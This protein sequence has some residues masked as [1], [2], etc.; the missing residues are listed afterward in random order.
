MGEGRWKP[1]PAYKDSWVEWLGEIPEHWDIKRLKYLAKANPSKSELSSVDRKLLVTFLPMELVQFG[2]ISLG[3]DRALEDV[4]QGFTYFRNGDVLIAKITP[5]FENGKGALAKNLTNGIGF[6][7]T[8]LHVLRSKGLYHPE[9]LYY[10][11]ISYIFRTVGAVFMHGTA[12][13]K[14][15]EDYFIVNFPSPIFSIAEQQAIANFLD[16]ETAKID[17]LI[18]K[19]LRLIELLQEKR[20]AL[21]SQ[22]V[23]K[24]LNPDVPMKDSGIEWLGEIP[25][26]WKVKK[27]KYV[28]K[29]FIGL[30]YD[31]S[32]VVDESN[33]MLVLRASNIINGRFSNEGNVFVNCNIPDNL[34]TKTNDILICARSGSRS[35]I[36][37]NIKL[38]H[39]RAGVTFGAFMLVFRSQYND[40]LSYVLNP[41]SLNISQVY[42]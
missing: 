29:A 42:F 4:Y 15:V 26:H 17:A 5:S 39:S 31:P 36:G 40:Y 18:A 3:E 20:T 28:G 30:T 7:T 21:I 2:D 13:Q 41:I 11:T 25:E 8:E 16:L 24:G 19:K 32:D 6:R 14:R 35:L 34:I 1:Y 22:A 37:K 9:Y 12:G 23:T 27:M 38:D 33:G 10:V